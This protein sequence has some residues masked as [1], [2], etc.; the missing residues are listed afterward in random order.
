MKLAKKQEQMGKDLGTCVYKV[1]QGDSYRAANEDMCHRAAVR[2][3]RSTG[4]KTQVFRQ[5]R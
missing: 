3:Q 4:P 1:A 2:I 5:C